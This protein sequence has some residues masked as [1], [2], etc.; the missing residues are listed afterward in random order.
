[1]QTA[2]VSSDI[3]VPQDGQPWPMLSIYSLLFIYLKQIIQIFL[4]LDVLY[5]N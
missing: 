5:S 4:I 3:R 1:M 2:A